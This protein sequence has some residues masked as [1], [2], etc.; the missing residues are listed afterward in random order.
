MGQ[1]AKNSDQS[2]NKLKKKSR[3]G[4]TEVP[5]TAKTG[6]KETTEHH[7]NWSA[8]HLQSCLFTGLDLSPSIKTEEHDGK[9]KVEE[10]QG[11]SWKSV[12]PV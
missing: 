8:M 1:D 7:F 3:R 10:N 9:G 6:V 5:L 2:K 11:C 12:F 4:G